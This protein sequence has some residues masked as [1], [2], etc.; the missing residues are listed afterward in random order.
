[1][2]TETTQ[3]QYRR[4]SLRYA[5]DVTDLRRWALIENFC[6]GPEETGATAHDSDARG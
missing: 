6:P 1:M 2:W 5:S 4:D 3:Q